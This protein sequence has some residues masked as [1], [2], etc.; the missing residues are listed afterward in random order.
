MGLSYATIDF[1]AG[2]SLQAFKHYPLI[3]ADERR[4]H[5]SLILNQFE[6][7]FGIAFEYEPLGDTA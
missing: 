3:A 1:G 7:F 5:H 4:R 2:E 6:K